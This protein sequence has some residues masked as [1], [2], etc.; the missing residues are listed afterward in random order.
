MGFEIVWGKL[1]SA[2]WNARFL[3]GLEGSIQVTLD[4]EGNPEFQPE[5]ITI[6]KGRALSRKQSNR[7]LCRYARVS[8]R[9]H[10][11]PNRESPSVKVGMRTISTG[12]SY[13]WKTAWTSETWTKSDHVRKGLEIYAITLN[14]LCPGSVGQMWRGKNKFS[15][16]GMNSRQAKRCDHIVVKG[17]YN[18]FQKQSY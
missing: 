1:I 9:W 12:L 14:L 2:A 6:F 11:N 7:K 5:S 17:G 16:E 10:F 8:L 4:T 3:S 13:I 18:E 15:S